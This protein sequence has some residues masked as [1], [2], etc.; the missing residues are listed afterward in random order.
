MLEWSPDR[1]FI[2]TG[3]VAAL[4]GLAVILN[5]KRT[6][7]IRNVVGS[8]LLYGLAGCGLGMVS[9]EYLH[10]KEYPWRV[11]GAGM[12]TGIQAVNW[13]LLRGAAARLLNLPVGE[14]NEH[15]NH[16]PK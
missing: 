13:S 8:I 10:G 1:L 7:S 5:S 11:I 16:P 12:L 4:G 6:L 15:G 14:D 2:A 3:I 9:Y